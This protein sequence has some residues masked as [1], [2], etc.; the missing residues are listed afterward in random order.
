MAR[1][2]LVGLEG[3]H[4]PTTFSATTRG[5]KYVRDHGGQDAEAGGVPTALAVPAMRCHAEPMERT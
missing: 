1:L 3:G 5:L 4:D 2:A